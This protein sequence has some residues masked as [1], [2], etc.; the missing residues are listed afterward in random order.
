MV[1]RS[2]WI[3]S[4]IGLGLMLGV[5]LARCNKSTHSTPGH[6]NDFGIK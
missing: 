3:V 2:L 6:Y 5:G 1:Q 4:V